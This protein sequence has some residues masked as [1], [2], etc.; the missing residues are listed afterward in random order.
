MRYILQTCTYAW[1]FEYIVGLRS[2]IQSLT[3][4]TNPPVSEVWHRGFGVY[5]CARYRHRGVELTDEMCN[6]NSIFACFEAIFTQKWHDQSGYR[7]WL[8]F[9]IEHDI[10]HELW[11]FVKITAR[12]TAARAR[13]S[14]HQSDHYGTKSASG[15]EK[16]SDVKWYVI[17]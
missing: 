14:K 7:P 4:H 12:A 1:H 13:N 15:S 17:S 10:A 2:K 6:K 8:H 9:S 5:V 3:A 11:S 16:L